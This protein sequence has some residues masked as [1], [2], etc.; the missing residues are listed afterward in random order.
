MGVFNNFTL[1]RKT[2]KNWIGLSFLIFHYRGKTKQIP[3]RFRNGLDLTIERREAFQYALLNRSSS[4]EGFNYEI[5]NTNLGP[6]VFICSNQMEVGLPAG[7]VLDL[8]QLNELKIFKPDGESL[9]DLLNGILKLSY[10]GKE[11]RLNLL[12]DNIQNGDLGLFLNDD[13]SFLRPSEMTV[14]DIGA[15]IADSA[16]YFAV[17]GA[18]K[19]I[20]C[21]PYP[22]AY[23]IGLENIRM[24]RLENIITLLNVGYGKDGIINV[25]D[26][27]TDSG[28]DLVINESGSKIETI[29][30]DTIIRRFDLTNHVVLKIDCEGCEYTLLNEKNEFL[31]RF[32]RIQIEYHYGY[33]QLEKKLISAGFRIKHSKPKKVYNQSN[34]NPK[35][36]VGML[37]AMLK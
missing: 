6:K 32:T 2:Y 27:P 37:Y 3:V 35:L 16:I 23:K 36:K 34:S 26:S 14:V 17:N 31:Q 8:I 1:L 18:K 22:Y 5:R 13:Y 11:L 24:N 7:L 25:T 19:V 10:R 15:N 33:P 20:A 21:E 9:H 12:K 29:S 28:S 4:V 30:L